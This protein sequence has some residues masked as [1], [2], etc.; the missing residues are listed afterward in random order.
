MLT[1]GDARYLGSLG[2]QS[3]S[4]PAIGLVPTKTG[5]GY[6]IALADGAVSAFG[7]ARTR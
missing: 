4:A 2:G 3:I 1:F 5:R 6:R 7:D